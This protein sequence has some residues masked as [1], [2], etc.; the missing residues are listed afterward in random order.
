MSEGDRVWQLVRGDEL[1]A[2]LVV[3]GG[4]FPWLNAKVRPGA[5]FAEVR[6]LFD[7]ELR[8]LKFLDDEPGQWEAAYRHI[9]EEVGLL[10][11]DGRP[12]PEFLL[13]IEG[14]DATASPASAA[15]RYVGSPCV[16]QAGPH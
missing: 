8:R 14:E 2:E 11:P 15:M 5:E 9:R 1:L 3:A 7:D 12:V 10:A 6:L 13:R 4:N 16:W